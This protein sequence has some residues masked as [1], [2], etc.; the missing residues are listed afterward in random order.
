MKLTLTI[1]L[2]TLIHHFA[3]G[4]GYF[5]TEYPAVWQRA[6]EYTLEV[7]EAMP[8]NKYGFTP[9]N[10]SMSFQGQMVHLIQNLSFLSGQITGTRPDFFDG[11]NPDLLSK[12]NVTALVR[13]S[14]GY[15]GELIK[16]TDEKT[17]R[18]RISFAGENMPKENIFYLMRDHMTHHRA[19]AILYLRLN[20]IEPP[21]YRGW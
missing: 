18:E 6:T 13:K 7:A 14:L 5:R 12:E 15:V 8:A 19:Q 3:S 21:K 2:C 16:T 20:G 11:A 10:E 4:Q 9:K 1:L 17:L